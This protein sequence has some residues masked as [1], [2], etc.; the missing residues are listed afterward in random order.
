MPQSITQDTKISPITQAPIAAT[1]KVDAPNQSSP[2]D[3]LGTAAVRDRMAVYQ[4][5]K[6]VHRSPAYV[7][8]FINAGLLKAYRRGG[9][10]DRPW[11]AVNLS[12]LLAAID[13]ETLYVPPTLVGRRAP[14]P[15]AKLADLHPLAAA[16]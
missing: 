2:S 16:L 10:V 7:L 15:R 14:K 5:A 4:A 6:A 1:A 8:A 13:R 12:E 3:R 9:P 11:L